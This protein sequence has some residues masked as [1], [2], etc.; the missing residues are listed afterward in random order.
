VS[1]TGADQGILW[2]LTCLTEAMEKLWTGGTR[3]QFSHNL[4]GKPLREDAPRL[5]TATWKTSNVFHSYHRI[6]DDE[7]IMNLEERKAKT[8]LRVRSTRTLHQPGPRLSP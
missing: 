3:P 1:L 6:D 8:T 5:P 4:L 7:C 2:N